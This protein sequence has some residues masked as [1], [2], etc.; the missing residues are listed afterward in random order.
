[1]DAKNDILTSLVSLIRGE[2]KPTVL[3]GT[4][5]TGSVS[6]NCCDVQPLDGALLKKVRLNACSDKAGVLATPS[7]GSFVIVVTLSNTDA[8]VAMFSEIDK[9]EVFFAKERTTI[10]VEDGTVKYKDGKN[11]EI[12]AAGGKVE[13]KNSS[14]SLKEELDSLLAA[15]SGAVIATPSGTGA[16]AADTVTKINQVKT[17]LNNL[18]C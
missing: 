18:L 11:L 16:F 14:A 4:V 15:L 8:F 5:V 13:I 17:N 1:M 3:I 9:V 2:M 12:T 6:G 10:S 7:D